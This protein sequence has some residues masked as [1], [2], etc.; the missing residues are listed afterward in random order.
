MRHGR[1]KASRKT[2]QFYRLNAHHIVSNPPYKILLDGTFLV[3]SIRNKVPLYER[4]S[5]ILQ[6]ESFICCVTRSTLVELEA[7]ANKWEGREEGDQNLFKIARQ[8][9]LDECEI[10]ECDRVPTTTTT[11]S[12]DDT[13]KRGSKNKAFKGFSQASQDIY[14]LSTVNGNNSS[15]YFVAT[16]DD[17]LSDALRSQPYVPLFRLGRAVLLLESPSSASRKYTG[18]LER[19]KLSTAGGLMT[20]EE[21]TMV[22]RVKKI[23]RMKRKEDMKEEQKKLEKRS[24]DEI[25]G[26]FTARRKKKAK[27]PNPLSVK[28]KKK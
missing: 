25:G 1:A 13:T 24:R 19:S 3:A 6:N 11:I 4:F 16:Q 18:S 27:G 12:T 23:D 22:N 5:K 2:L 26:G 15:A 17:A 21:R 9:G 20:S 8:Y 28:K 14:Q 7:L 10:I